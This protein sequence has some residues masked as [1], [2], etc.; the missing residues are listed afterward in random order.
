[1][2]DFQTNVEEKS[3]LTGVKMW[4]AEIKA[5]QEFLKKFK[6]DAAKIND[7]YLDKRDAYS[8]NEQRINLFWSTIQVVMSMLFSRS[9]QVT[10]KREYGDFNDD[11]ARVASIIL[12]RLL[13][14]DLQSDT[15]VSRLGFRQSI[16]DWVIVGMGQVWTRYD[17]E[18]ETDVIEEQVIDPQTGQPIIEEQ[19]YD[20]LVSEDAVLEHVFWDDFLFS[21]ARTWEEVRW[22]ARRI[23]LTKEELAERFGE[24]VAKRVPLTKSKPKMDDPVDNVKL[25]KDPWS[26]AEVWEIWDKSA[27]KVIWYAKNCEF[28]LDE[29]EDPLGLRDFFPCPPP[30]LANTTTSELVPRS[31]YIMAQDQFDQLDEI[32][33]RISWLTRGMKL[34]GVYD[35]SA[36]GVQRMLNQA[37]ENQLIPVDNWALFSESGGLKGKVEWMPIQDV[38]A[39]LERLVMLR[40]QVKAQIYEVLGISDIMRGASKASETAAAQQIKAQFGSTR[41]NEKQQA[42]SMFVQGALNLKAQIIE[43]HFS[44]ETMATESNVMMT[45]DAQMA[46]P[47][48]QLLKSGQSG[49]R[50]K[51]QADSMAYQDEKALIDQRTQALTAMGQFLQQAHQAAQVLPTSAP[52]FLEMMKWYMSSFTGFQSIEGVFD[53]AIDEANKQAQAP[54][55]PSPQE[56]LEMAK[57]K[58][59]ISRTEAEIEEK[60]AGSMERRAGANKD[61]ADAIE[62]LLPL[63]INLPMPV[64]MVFQGIPKPP[65]IAPPMPPQQGQMPPQR[66]Q[67]PVQPPVM[68]NQPP[69]PPTPP[70]PP[71]PPRGQQ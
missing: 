22:V 70:M 24:D 61:L 29:R 4:A 45:P 57:T 51:V 44:P 21:P 71:M 19:S 47:A 38:A 32:N 55:Q 17:A 56:Q 9:P 6:K 20:R 49:F 58:A 60:K 30:L 36:D 54:K 13:N 39:V 2:E 67:M 14:N 16:Q 35:K 8:D 37:T 43:R 65:P 46:Q 64:E 26:R 48:L 66:P 42:V 23:Y 59:D 7:R 40:E 1:M 12:D 62:K 53:R 69:M 25:P 31:D 63:G 68:P 27:K 18:I 34:V 15:S 33:T 50:V 3:N 5:S 41:V 11:T 28:L 52:M 10:V